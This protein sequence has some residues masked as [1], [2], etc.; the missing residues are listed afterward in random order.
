MLEIVIVDDSAED[1]GFAE[2]VFKQCKI[3][4]PITLLHSGEQC[5]SWFEEKFQTGRGKQYLVILDLVM[6]P[7]TGIAVLRHLRTKKLAEESVFIMLSGITDIKSI[8]AGYQLGAKTFLV[9]PIKPE[10]ILDLLTN[11]KNQIIVE[12]QPEG[13]LLRWS[14]PASAESKTPDTGFFKRGISLSA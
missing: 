5:I 14:S 1:L 11:L 6:A 2:R 8:N 9:K 4:N 12:E 7:T 3:L 13:Y 10:D